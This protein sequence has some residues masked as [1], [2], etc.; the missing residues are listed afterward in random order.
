MRLDDIFVNHRDDHRPLRFRPA[1][2]FDFFAG[3]HGASVRAS[4]F[5]A[6]ADDYAIVFVRNAHDEVHPLVMLDLPGKDGSFIASAGGARNDR[7]PAAPVSAYPLAFIESDGH[8]TLRISMEEDPV[9]QRDIVRVP[10]LGAELSRLDLLTAC[11]AKPRVANPSKSELAGFC[12]VDEGKLNAL[13]DADL[14]R[15][16][17]RGYLPLITAHLLSLDNLTFVRTSQRRYSSRPIRSSSG[18]GGDNQ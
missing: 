15:L 13:G 17:R 16:A 14:L 5:S 6:A 3:V 18:D 11:Y 12:I 1:D 10:L 8:G 7:R 9:P 4:E 2:S